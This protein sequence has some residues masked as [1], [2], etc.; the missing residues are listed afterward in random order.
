MIQ[1]FYEKFGWY[2]RKFQKFLYFYVQVSHSLEIFQF[3][4]TFW[5][6]SDFPCYQIFQKFPN[7]R[8]SKVKNLNFF[9]FLFLNFSK[10]KKIFFTFKNLCAIKSCFESTICKNWKAISISIQTVKG[11]KKVWIVCPHFWNFFENDKLHSVSPR[12]CE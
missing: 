12:K 5:I 1:T 6:S 7:S 9:N 10:L 4:E 3:L 2:L 8:I 11:L